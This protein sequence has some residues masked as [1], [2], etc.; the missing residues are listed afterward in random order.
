[1][2]SA[3]CFKFEQCF[4]KRVVHVRWDAAFPTLGFVQTESL[5]DERLPTCCIFEAMFQHLAEV[6]RTSISASEV[7]TPAFLM[8]PNSASRPVSLQFHV[9]V[10]CL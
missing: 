3:A 4:V 10:Q 1:M 6:R 5:F 2:L 7:R 8:S 9:A